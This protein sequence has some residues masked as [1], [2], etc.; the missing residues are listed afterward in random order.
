MSPSK[1]MQ[2][3]RPVILALLGAVVVLVIAWVVWPAASQPPAPSN[4]SRV[5]PKPPAQ[6][7]TTGRSAAPP[8]GLLPGELDVRLDA[9]KQPP[10]GQNDASRNP[11]RFYVKPPPPAPPPPVVKAPTVHVDPGPPPPPP[12]PPPPPPIPLKFIGTLE[13]GG[14]RWA[15]FSDGRGAP[16][17][18]EEGKTILGQYKIVKIGVESVVMEYADGRGRQT[19]P[20]RGQ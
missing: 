9:L 20:M 2:R 19:I 10:P 8:S 1:V 18:G 16:L 17:Y 7:A 13:Q 15:I 11:F 14:K 5:Q 3:P 4:Q 6:T 12:G